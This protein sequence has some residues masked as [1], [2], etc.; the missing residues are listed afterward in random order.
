MLRHAVQ[1]P[2]EWRLLQWD[3]VKHQ[4]I[5][6]NLCEQLSTDCWSLQEENKCVYYAKLEGFG[7]FRIQEN[8]KSGMLVNS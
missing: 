4:S 5:P 7:F 1:F 6:I 3:H 8:L 2:V